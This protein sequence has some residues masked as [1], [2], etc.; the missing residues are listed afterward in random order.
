MRTPRIYLETTIFNYYF[1]AERGDEHIATVKLFE[2]I[3]EGGYDPFTSLYVTGELEATKDEAKR[4]K[5][6]E[7][8]ARYEIP[9]LAESDAAANLAAIYIKETVI[10]LRFRTDG[11]HI[12]IASVNDLDIVVSANFQHIVKP[13]TIRLSGAINT[14]NGYHAVQIYSPT[15]VLK[16]EKTRAD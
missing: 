3:A 1:D 12:A 2:R 5:M 15:E 14:A 6:L 10:P 16:Y 8:I 4:E 7:L 13:K 9:V 11:L